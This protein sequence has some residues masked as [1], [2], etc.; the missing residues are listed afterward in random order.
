MPD[1]DRIVVAD[2]ARN[3]EDWTDEDLV[4]LAERDAALWGHQVGMAQGRRS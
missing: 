4:R 1:A 3:V 2:K